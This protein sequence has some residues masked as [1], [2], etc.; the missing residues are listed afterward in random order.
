[1]LSGDP[2]MMCS[3]RLAHL[4]V[5][6]GGDEAVGLVEHDAKVAVAL[7]HGGVD[8]G[9]Q[10]LAKLLQ[11]DLRNHTTDSSLTAFQP[12]GMCRHEYGRLFAKLLQDDLHNHHSH[13]ICCFPDLQGVAGMRMARPGRTGLCSLAA[14]STCARIHARKKSSSTSCRTIASASERPMEG[15]AA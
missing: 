11:D 12:P 6:A 1:M 2:E 10:P 4:K 3:N 8:R 9:V 13:F 15:H 5:G 7:R 14:S